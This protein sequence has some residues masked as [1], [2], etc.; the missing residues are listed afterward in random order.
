M[1]PAPARGSLASRARWIAL[2][3]VKISG[4]RSLPTPS[5]RYTPR[6][7]IGLGRRRRLVARG[8]GARLADD[9]VWRSQ[10]S[11]SG[12]SA[13]S[14]P[15]PGQQG[16]LELRATCGEPESRD[17]CRALLI[18]RASALA[19]F[20]RL[21]STP[22]LSSTTHP[23]HASRTPQSCLLRTPTRSPMRRPRCK[24]PR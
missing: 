7:A 13:T 16:E 14:G 3:Q 4:C 17:C 11:W 1:R 8:P 23:H 15:A 6:R 19:V 2:R 22:S 24:S 10:P 5:H 9:E 21:H 20:L 18:K 12:G